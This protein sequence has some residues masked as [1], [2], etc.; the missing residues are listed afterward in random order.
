MRALAAHHNPVM[1]SP[2]YLISQWL[3]II[4]PTNEKSDRPKWKPLNYGA[5]QGRVSVS[6]P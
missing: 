5:R 1:S 4:L 2:G 6:H 3:T